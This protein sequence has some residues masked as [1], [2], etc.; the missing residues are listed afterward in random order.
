MAIQEFARPPLGLIARQTYANQLKGDRMSYYGRKW[1]FYGKNIDTYEDSFSEVLHGSIRNLLKDKEDLVVID[2]MSPSGALKTLFQ[3][4][5]NGKKFGLAVS[6]EDLRTGKEKREDA[7]LNIAQISGDILVPSTWKRIEEQLQG[8]KADLIMERAVDGLICIPQDPRLYAVFSNKI[9][10]LLKKDEGTL[11]AEFPG[12][13]NLLV[14]EMISALKDDNRS[15][16]SL[17]DSYGACYLR[18]VKTPNSP[19]KL[20]FPKM[21]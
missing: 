8:R 10:G 6:L 18:L 15:M 1:G 14:W 2:L 4:L 20:P 5:P 7:K 3:Q 19:E 17:K 13:Y 11:L 12:I 9:W 16:L 21:R